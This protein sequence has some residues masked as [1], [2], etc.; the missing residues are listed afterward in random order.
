MFQKSHLTFIKQHNIENVL[1]TCF[2]VR[3]S[4]SVFDNPVEPL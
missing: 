3:V 4:V 2:C 1:Y